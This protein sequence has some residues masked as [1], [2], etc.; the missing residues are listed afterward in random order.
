[1]AEIFEKSGKK[2][3]RNA[4]GELIPQS[5]I[6]S[7]EKKSD[8]LVEKIHNR[9]ERLHEKIVSE[10]QKIADGINTYLDEIS[11]ENNAGEFE[12]NTTLYNFDKTKQIEVKISKHFVADER[13]NIAKAKIDQCIQK[14]SSGA[15]DNIIALVNKAFKVDRKGNVDVHQLKSLRELK[16]KDKEWK[17]A[18]TL[19]EDS[20]KV[21]VTKTYFNFRARNEDGKLQSIPLNFSAL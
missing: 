8:R 17:E 12:G 18:M 4:E 16:I 7:H 11:K 10:K 6:F 21:D 19:I 1:M 2:Y 13:L 9:V 20:I 14:W 5:R 3:W 15:N